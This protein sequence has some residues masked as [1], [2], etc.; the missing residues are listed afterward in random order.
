MRTL[1]LAGLVAVS[2][3]VVTVPAAPAKA[4]GLNCWYEFIY[5]EGTDV[6]IDVIAHCEVQQEEVEP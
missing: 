3:A 4:G 6:I 5:A 1:L 2:A